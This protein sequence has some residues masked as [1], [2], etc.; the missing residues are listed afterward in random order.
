MEQSSRSGIALSLQLTSPAHGLLCQEGGHVDPVGIPAEALVNAGLDGLIRDDLGAAGGD[1]HP[2][3]DALF[4]RQL[5][6][7]L[8]ILVVDVIVGDDG[9]GQNGVGVQLHRRVHQLFHRD[10]GA[11]VVNLD[12]PLFNAAVLVSWS[13]HS[14]EKI[15]IHSRRRQASSSGSTVNGYVRQH[16]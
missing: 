1:D 13:W 4:H 2:V 9:G 14:S 10:G 5:V 3:T 12:P 11:Q 7:A 6:D 16:N 8:H 15:H